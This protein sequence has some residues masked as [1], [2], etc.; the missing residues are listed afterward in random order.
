MPRENK[1]CIDK[2]TAR[3]YLR[4]EHSFNE[5]CVAMHL[6][7]DA[8]VEVEGWKREMF[9]DELHEAWQERVAKKPFVPRR[10]RVAGVQDHTMQS[11]R[12]GRKK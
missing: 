2:D 3:Y 10:E 8:Y 9:R 4:L 7:P 5:L 11:L 6:D 12:Q 1:V